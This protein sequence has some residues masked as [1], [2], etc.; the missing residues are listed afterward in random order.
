MK[1]MATLIVIGAALAAP[2][3]AAAGNSVQVQP[4]VKAQVVTTQ[5]HKTQ[6]H[7]TQV[8][9]AQV[10]QAQLQLNRYSMLRK[11]RAR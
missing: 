5:V 3:V 7:K 11:I 4:Q 9:K 10:V 1:R 2:S 8:H 6:V